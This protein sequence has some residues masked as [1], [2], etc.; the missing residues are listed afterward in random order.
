[1][2]YQITFRRDDNFIRIVLCWLVMEDEEFLYV[3]FA[4]D[5]Q[6]DSD[7]YYDKR[8]M[9]QIKKSAVLD[10]EPLTFCGAPVEVAQLH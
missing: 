4:Q 7:F 5:K 2:I 1:M 10:M 3:C 6:G 9:M 8:N